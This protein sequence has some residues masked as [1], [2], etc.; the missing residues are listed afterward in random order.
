MTSD[1]GQG[2]DWEWVF[3][4]MPLSADL[5]G[6]H[7]RHKD[8]FNRPDSVL[9]LWTRRAVK[10]VNLA[11]IFSCFVVFAPLNIQSALLF[12]PVKVSE[13]NGFFCPFTLE[14]GEEEL[15]S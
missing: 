1:R 6:F 15:Q 7:R 10:Q 9:A 14:L 4:N 8:L 11:L 5:T 12:A 3:S 2:S 13:S